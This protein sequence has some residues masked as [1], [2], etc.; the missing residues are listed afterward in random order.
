MRHAPFDDP[1]WEA[2]K[3]HVGFVTSFT[4]REVTLLGGNQSRTVRVQT[5]PLVARDAA[6][7]VRSRFVAF[8]MPVMN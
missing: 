5:Y 3:G 1:R 7:D 8:V 4:E 6:G 2:G